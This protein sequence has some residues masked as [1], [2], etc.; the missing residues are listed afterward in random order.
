MSGG[1][2]LTLGSALALAASI[3]AGPAFAADQLQP[4][5][6]NGGTMVRGG[7]PMPEF[8][9]NFLLDDPGRQALQT[10]GSEGDVEIALT[11]PNTGV[12]HFLFSPR[13]QF[14]YGYD[15]LT[16]VNRGFA[17]FT[18][19]LF[20]S[21]SLFGSFGLAGSVDAGTNTLG[22]D[23]VRRSLEQPMMLQGALEFGY[24]LGDQHSLSLRLDESHTPD[25]RFN[26]T[27]TSDSL[28]LRYGLKF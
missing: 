7:A 24:R 20:D 13:P 8:H 2:R 5:T 25:L 22:T 10:P 9:L 11:S 12:F 15:R 14:G 19:N 28:R 1:L 23:P 18:W 17:G 16:G 3:A 6:V 26:N 27:E 21:G 4:F